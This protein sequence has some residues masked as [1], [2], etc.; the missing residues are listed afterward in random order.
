MESI[1]KV[2][3]FGIDAEYGMARCRRLEVVD[4]IGIARVAGTDGKLVRRKARQSLAGSGSRGGL[5]SAGDHE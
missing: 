2:S 4:E 1:S 3:G 5:D